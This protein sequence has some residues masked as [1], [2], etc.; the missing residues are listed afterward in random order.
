MFFFR[1]TDPNDPRRGMNRGEDARVRD[2]PPGNPAAAGYTRLSR[3]DRETGIR[4]P[5]GSAAEIFG[6]FVPD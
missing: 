4:S 2:E 6:R 3:A 5:V 1:Q